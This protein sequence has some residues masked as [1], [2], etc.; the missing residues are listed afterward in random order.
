MSTHAGLDSIY[1]YFV[2]LSVWPGPAS[3]LEY[4]DVGHLRASLCAY[5]RSYQ[6]PEVP[7]LAERVLIIGNN[8]E[9]DPRC[10]VIAFG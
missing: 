1:I 10:S 5:L 7:T 2:V 8:P 3:H 9:V 6:L 4:H